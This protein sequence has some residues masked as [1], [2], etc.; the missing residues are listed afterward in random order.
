MESKKKKKPQSLNA[1]KISGLW[2]A[3]V[4]GRGEEIAVK[5]SVPE[6]HPQRGGQTEGRRS[7]GTDL[8]WSGMQCT[9]LWMQLTLPYDIQE[10]C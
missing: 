2:L 4:G 8:Q 3:E 6:L 5:Y 7:K 1:E 10:I 9:P